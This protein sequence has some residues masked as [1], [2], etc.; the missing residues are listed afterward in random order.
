MIIQMTLTELN[1]IGPAQL[2]EEFM[3]CCGCTS[4]AEKMVASVPFQNREEVFEKSDLFWNETKAED[5]LEAFL[6]HPKIGD[7]KSLEK[8]FASTSKLAGSEQASV[9]SASQKT[10]EDLAAG[11]DAY[12]NKFGFIFIVCATGKSAGEMLELLNN[13]MHNNK[14]T[15]LRIAAA[16]QNKITRLRLEKLLS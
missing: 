12:E 2:R 14:E 6:H 3:K 1:Q 10:L 5:W 13:R 8:K 4:W 16:E 15:E 11:N 9:H 7:L